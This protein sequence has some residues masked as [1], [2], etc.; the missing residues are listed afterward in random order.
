MRQSGGM[1]SVDVR[2]IGGESNA[3]CSVRPFW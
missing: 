3:T 1:G 2:Q